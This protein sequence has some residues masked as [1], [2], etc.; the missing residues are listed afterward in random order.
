MGSCLLFSGSNGC[1]Y[2]IDKKNQCLP[3][4]QESQDQIIEFDNKQFKSFYSF[5][6]DKQNNNITQQINYH[7]EFKTYH[8]GGSKIKYPVLTN[9]KFAN[10]LMANC[11]LA[12]TFNQ[13]M[14]VKNP[15]IY[16]GFKCQTSLLEEIDMIPS[17]Y[18]QCMKLGKIQMQELQIDCCEEQILQEM[19]GKCLFQRYAPCIWDQTEDKCKTIPKEKEQTKFNA[20]AALIYNSILAC[21]DCLYVWRYLS[22]L[23]QHQLWKI[24]HSILSQLATTMGQIVL[25]LILNQILIQKEKLLIGMHVKRILFQQGNRK[26]LNKQL[27]INISVYYQLMI[28][29]ILIFKSSSASNICK[30]LNNKS[31]QIYE[32]RGCLFDE[33][34]CKEPENIES[35]FQ[36]SQAN[37]IL[38]FTQRFKSCQWTNQ[39]CQ[40]YQAPTKCQGSQVSVL[41]YQ[42]A[43]D[44]P[45][46]AAYFHDCFA[47]GLNRNACLYQTERAF[48]Y[49]Q[50]G[51]CKSANF[52]F[53]LCSDDVSQE[54][55]L[56][57][58]TDGQ[59]SQLGLLKEKMLIQL[60]LYEIKYETCYIELYQET[61]YEPPLTCN[62]IIDKFGCV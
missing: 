7:E 37:I 49:Y 6:P 47:N 43:T 61:D 21:G 24:V 13:F 1:M 52:I 51:T 46:V 23:F 36:C 59:V 32:A 14:E 11:Q 26:M 25:H 40:D 27:Q 35:N 38:C 3:I 34:G 4:P 29:T 20:Q 18:F 22:Q 56:S 55:C 54:T 44:L 33:Q 57:I 17:N 12:K 62:F 50:Q 42:N 39:K 41:G 60:A 10:M 15:C 28:P 53:Q 8:V 16:T 5:K 48:C 19:S 2:D 30:F 45:Y 58:V 9:K 31:C